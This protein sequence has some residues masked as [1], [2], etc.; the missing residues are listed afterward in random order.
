MKKR[1][2]T[3]ADAFAMELRDQLNKI[4]AV[5]GNNG[6]SCKAGLS[7]THERADVRLQCWGNNKTEVLIEVE[8]RRGNPVI[9]ALK[10]WRWARD[11]KDKT[12]IVLFHALSQYFEKGGNGKSTPP[13]AIHSRSMG[14]SVT[15]EGCEYAVQVR[16]CD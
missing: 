13:G 5:N 10:T 1:K 14:Q 15:L 6:W 7:G 12:P 4:T 16:T 3:R 2:L 8:L 11:R 9:N